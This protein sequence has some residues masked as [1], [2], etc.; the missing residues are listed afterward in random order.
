MAPRRVRR[1]SMK[2][3]FLAAVNPLDFLL[4]LSEEIETRELD[5]ASV[6][7]QVGLVANFLFLLARA[8]LGSSNGAEDDVFGDDDAGHGWVSYLVQLLVWTGFT[9]SV[10]NAVYVFSRKRHYRLFEANID[11]NPVT[12]SAHR[13]RVQSS[14]TSASPLRLLGDLVG[15]DTAESRSHPD[16]S[17]DVWEVAVWDPRPT[18]LAL[19]SFFSPLHV[20]VYMFELPLDPLEPRPSVVVFKC[21]VFQAGLS[22][23]MKLVQSRNDQRQKDNA[24][25]QKE[26][27]HEYDTK[28]V[29][30]HLHP[31][32]RDVGTQVTMND[33]LSAGAGNKS[34][35]IPVELGQPTTL[36]RRNFET[37][38]NANYL[39]HIDPDYVGS[40][41][42]RP[43]PSLT[44]RR[45][46]TPVNRQTR[47]SDAFTTEPSSAAP[48]RQSTPVAT[49][50]TGTSTSAST[51]TNTSTASVPVGHTPAAAASAVGNVANSSSTL[52]RPLSSTGMNKQFGG[53]LGVYSHVNSPLKK[54]TSVNDVMSSA[55][56]FSPRNSRELAAMEQREAVERIQRRASPIKE[57]VFRSPGDVRSPFRAR[58]QDFSGAANPFSR[59]RPGGS[60][61]E[62]FPSRC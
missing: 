19:L 39:K 16:S 62:R 9:L 2:Q 23:L 57:E 10:A 7:T 58:S 36:I 49:V 21:V 12:P 35:Q 8:N 61:I 31:V 56:P 13:V 30:P 54:S 3:R 22:V 25:I 59:A 44:P 38:P 50:S 28:F 47:Y 34:E 15:F 17:R 37:H 45:L 29:Q 53:N 42:S 52:R 43:A 40:L 26:V 14:P 51:S 48:S 55:I 11:K 20:L 41:A 60:K 18:S 46:F 6:G 1:Q 5:S 4:W 24:L 27:M 33:I 32:V